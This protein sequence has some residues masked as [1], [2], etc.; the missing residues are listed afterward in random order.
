MKYI[1]TFLFLFCAISNTSSQTKKSIDSLNNISF[2]IRIAQASSFTK[3]YLRNVKNSQKI[4]YL[5]GEAD[6][7][8]NLGLV[9]YYQGKYELDV[10]YSL[11]AI[12]IYKKWGFS[13]IGSHTFDL[14]GD[15]H[16]PG[17]MV[18]RLFPMLMWLPMRLVLVAR[19]CI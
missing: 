6:S 8:S 4:I 13:E 16:F 10:N 3:K 14:G 11:K 9:H 15:I 5:K 1:I 12:E 19:L 18:V 2:E 7:Y 17:A